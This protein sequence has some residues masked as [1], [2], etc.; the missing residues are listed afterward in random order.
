MELQNFT[1]EEL[2]AQGSAKTISPQGSGA[3]SESMS[4]VDTTELSPLSGDT[5]ALST[6]LLQE[7]RSRRKEEW[8]TILWA[9]A[10]VATM[11]W[12]AT[13]PG[14]DVPSLTRNLTFCFVLMGIMGAGIC[15]QLYRRSYRRKRSLISTLDSSRDISHVGPLIQSLRVQNTPVRNLAKHAL[16]TLLPT[17]MASDAAKIGDSERAVL[18]RVLAI[19]PN[20]PSYRDLRELFSP[21]AFR[22]EMELRLAIL[23]AYEQVGGEKEL[24][25][26]ERLSQGKSMPGTLGMP[27]EIR[28]AAKECLPYLQ[29][30]ASSENARAQL[31]RGSSASSLP[32]GGLLRPV[33]AQMDVRPEQLMR[34]AEPPA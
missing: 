14:S 10:F 33:N 25:G 31:L 29:L 15:V 17:M 19:P 28:E 2:P 9:G 20:D 23:K 4:D 11:G 8:T 6:L 24:P 21:S 13:R 3:A 27:R 26:V 12:M 34:A 18:L 1:Q 16:I 22:R 30:R 7:A 32:D 5:T